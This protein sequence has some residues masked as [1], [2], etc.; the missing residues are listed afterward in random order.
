MTMKPK[1]EY[2][3]MYWRKNTEKEIIYIHILNYIWK[4]NKNYKYT[5][6]ICGFI[7][8]LTIYYL[9]ALCVGGSKKSVAKKT[10]FLKLKVF[11]V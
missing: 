2:K 10:I 7:Y 9:R 6:N 1:N 8:T 5:K 4:N 3:M 11:V